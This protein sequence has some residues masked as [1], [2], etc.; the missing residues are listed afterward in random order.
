MKLLIFL[1]VDGVLNHEPETKDCGDALR[2]FAGD[3]PLGG[4]SLLCPSCI[5]RLNEL[6]GFAKLQKFYSDVKI[7]LSSTWRHYFKPD[8]FT[9]LAREAGL[10]YEVSDSTESDSLPRGQQIINFI[11]K[12]GDCRW[13]AIDDDTFDMDLVKHQQV[14]TNYQT[15][16]D[17]KA[18]EKS[19]QLILDI[20]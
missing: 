18:L 3:M 4:F 1:D 9:E 14:V 17:C 2:K 8:K 11:K 5:S 20:K 12:E 7:V 6:V 19:I 16:F 10:A 13:I 15:G